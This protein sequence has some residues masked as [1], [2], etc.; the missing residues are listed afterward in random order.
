MEVQQHHR[1][2]SCWNEEVVKI[3]NHR[4]RPYIEVTWDIC[5]DLVKKNWDCRQTE[6]ERLELEKTA[7][8]LFF[9]KKKCNS[10]TGGSP[11]GWEAVVCIWQIPS[12]DEAVFTQEIYS[13]FNGF[14]LTIV[15]L[16]FVHR[17]QIDDGSEESIWFLDKKYWGVESQARWKLGTGTSI[18]WTIEISASNAF[19]HLRRGGCWL[20]MNLLEGG[21]RNI[22]SYPNWIRLWWST[23][24]R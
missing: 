24:K 18:F 5:H 4:D 16:V 20:I 23:E 9:L 7:D 12:D 1:L 3:K 14:L 2:G 11:C 13:G 21:N 6:Q 10:D 19:W 8:C 22:N 15:L 17:L